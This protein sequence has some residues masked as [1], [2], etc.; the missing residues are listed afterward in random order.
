[1]GSAEADGTRVKPMVVHFRFLNLTW[2]RRL[3]AAVGE[4]ITD[5]AHGT[6]ATGHMVADAADG[7]VGTGTR[8]GIGA[9]LVNASQTGQA[10]RALSTLGPAMGWHTEVV[11]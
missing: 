10:L 9:S 4:R 6:L 1:M 2:W 7:I 11:G 5:V 8:A 3:G